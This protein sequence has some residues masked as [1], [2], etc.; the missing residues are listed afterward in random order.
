MRKTIIAA[1]A[2]S[3]VLGIMGGTA[4]ADSDK[5]PGHPGNGNK[6]ALC[7]YTAATNTWETVYV[8]T[9]QVGKKLAQGQYPDD[10][11]NYGECLPA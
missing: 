1:V 2:T 11:Y 4:S 7:R 10:T 6:T 3:A 8:P 5:L 9:S